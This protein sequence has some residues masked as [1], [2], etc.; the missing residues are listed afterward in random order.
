M[1]WLACKA[2]GSS[3]SRFA[4]SL[5][6]AR[7]TESEVVGAAAR[8]P[9]TR[10]ADQTATLASSVSTTALRPSASISQRVASSIE[11]PIGRQESASNRLRAISA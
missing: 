11:Q 1:S 9:S 2:L 7:A 4:L 6:T 8:M 3:A 5:A 10:L